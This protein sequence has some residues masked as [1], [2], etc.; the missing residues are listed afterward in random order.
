MKSF[1]LIDRD[2]FRSA[3]Q[4]K[5]HEFVCHVLSQMGIPED[6]LIDCLSEDVKDFSVEQ[7]IKLRALLNKFNVNVIDDRDGGI[8]IYLDREIV[9]EWK[10]S[11]F[12][13]KEDPDEI[14]PSKKIYAE[15]HMDFWI[16][17]ED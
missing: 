13:L 9:A 2:N 10:K 4:Q 1:I 16:F 11:Y 15:M 12:F 6:Q 14:D 5:Q 8:K 3:E 17:Q 7:K